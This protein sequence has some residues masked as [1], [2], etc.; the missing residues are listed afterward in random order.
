MLSGTL[1][2]KNQPNSSKNL[3]NQKKRK[4]KKEEN[5]QIPPRNLSKP[6]KLLSN[7]PQNAIKNL[8][9]RNL[10]NLRL[11]TGLE[12]SQIPSKPTIRTLAETSEQHEA[13]NNYA[14]SI[15]AALLCQ[16]A[17]SRDHR[18]LATA[19]GSSECR[20]RVASRARGS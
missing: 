8:S 1:S 2:L 14:D 7:F 19:E 4:E 20:C 18:T 9:N 5:S 12:I 3:S 15:F 6:I 13:Y 17:E 16:G 10:S 11:E